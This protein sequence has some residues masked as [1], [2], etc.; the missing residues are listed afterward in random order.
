[1]AEDAVD[2]ACEIRPEVGKKAK[3]DCVTSTMQLIGADRGG[4]V[5][6]KNFDR[7]SIQ[8][9][10]VYGMDKDVVRTLLV[11][12]EADSPPKSEIPTGLILFKFLLTRRERCTRALLALSISDP[13]LVHAPSFYLFRVCYLY[14]VCFC[15]SF[16]LLLTCAC[17]LYVLYYVSPRVLCG[18]QADHLVH[19]YGTRALQL[20]EM[21][22]KEPAG[23]VRV[24]VKNGGEERSFWKRLSPQHPQLEAEVV[25][26]CRHEYA[27]TLVDVVARRTRLGFLDVKATLQVLPRVLDLMQEE[28]KWTKSKRDQEEADCRRFMETMYLPANETDGDGG[29]NNGEATKPLSER[30]LY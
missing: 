22:V 30:L 6:H 17:I 26:A 20:A 12:T 2:K 23:R 28:L 7:V 8:L 21:A 19:N 24:T 27:E 29:V 9:R 13:F 4:L 11:L 18:I 3:N 15:F 14:L 25:F 16:L 10:E 5:C 1:M